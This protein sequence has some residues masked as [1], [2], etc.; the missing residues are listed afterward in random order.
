MKIR[1]AVRN[2]LSAVSLLRKIKKLG[3]S[4]T[5]IE[6]LEIAEG[7]PAIRPTQISSE[8]LQL[9]SLVAEQKCRY[10][11]EIGTYRGGT[12]FVFTRLA[13]PDATVISL[14]YHFSLFGKICRIFQRPLFHS[15]ARSGQHVVLVREDSHKP[16]TLGI[17]RKK[18]ARHSLDFLFIDGDH[19]YE[20][21]KADF[22]MYSPLVRPGGIVAFHDVAQDS[23]TIKVQ[24]FW[25]E[26][27][28]NYLH[29]EIVDRSSDRTYGIGILWI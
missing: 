18:L 17:I 21:V 28:A 23:P 20:G 2:S 25:N 14:D 22:E 24:K 8:F 9:A 16:E 10:V 26:I 5:P 3:D 11:L 7:C 27:K 13:A 1:S 6:L 12:L 29:R 4:P 19:S 15:F